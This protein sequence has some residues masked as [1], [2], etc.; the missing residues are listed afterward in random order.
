MIGLG[1]YDDAPTWYR[2]GSGCSIVFLVRF[3]NWARR[4][5]RATLS[6]DRQ[7]TIRQQVMGRRILA[8]RERAG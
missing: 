5:G 4:L 7:Q 2:V 3:W 1:K 6:H 8:C